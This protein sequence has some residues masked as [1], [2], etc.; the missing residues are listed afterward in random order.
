MDNFELKPVTQQYVNCGDKWYLI[1]LF[2]PQINL[3]IEVD[4][5]HH[6]KQVEQDKI[7]T[8][9]IV[10]AMHYDYRKDF[11][12]K[13]VATSGK[14]LDEI[15]Q[16]INEIV[17]LIRNKIEGL[18]HEL[19]WETYEEQVAKIRKSGKLSVRDNISFPNMTK[20][21]NDIFN[22]GRKEGSG[23]YRGYFRCRFNKDYWF[24][25]A[26][27][28]VFKKDKEVAQAGWIN[29]LS[30][31]GKTI[32]EFHKDWDTSPSPTS[33]NKRI[34]FLKYRNSLRQDGYKFVGIFQGDGTTITEFNGK[35]VCASKYRLIQD[36]I[37]LPKFN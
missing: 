8:D 19:H 34:T 36:Y 35:K 28:N 22:Y 32:I 27:R 14:R 25:F 11:D 26:K 7:R 2:F 1:D 31:D 6:D 18:E 9:Q 30:K 16:Q 21:L 29:R 3:G 12:I 17:D 13:R 33:N 5:I 15:I 4:E 20:A 10:T 37:E 24:W 23:R